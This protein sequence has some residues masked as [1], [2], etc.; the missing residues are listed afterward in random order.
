MTWPVA[1][2][3]TEDIRMYSES[4][5]RDEYLGN[6]LYL[7]ILFVLNQSCSIF[8]LNAMHAN[9]VKDETFLS[10][11]K[12]NVFHGRNKNTKCYLP[13]AFFIK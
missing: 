11:N 3:C 2:S 6:F 8:V 7:G 13:R 1:D 12:T 4:S 5:S 10:D 9:T